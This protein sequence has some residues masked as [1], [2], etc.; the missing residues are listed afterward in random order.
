MAR[1]K[2][3]IKKIDNATARQVTFSKRRRGLFKK[4]Q[5]LAILCDVDVGLIVF[6]AS[7]KVFDY[8][9]S[10]MCEILHKHS[11]QPDN[12]VKPD[13]QTLDLLKN[14][15]GYA[16]LMKDYADQ[17]RQLRQMRGEDLQGL[18]LEELVRLERTIDNGLARVIER[19]GQ[20]I[21]EELNSLQQK[22]MQ[23]LEENKRLKEK[24]EEMCIVEKQAVI[25]HD[26]MNGFLED[27]QCSS[28]SVPEH[29][30]QPSDTSLKLGPPSSDNWD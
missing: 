24:M 4:A 25:D 10:S 16:A 3:K 30:D 14:N 29:C 27:V 19:K 6:S 8:A 21:M 11:I 5:E 22:G 23:L 1:D 12:S 15:S 7:G 28:E 18:T 20:Q 9:S 26:P 13:E 2:I 17:L